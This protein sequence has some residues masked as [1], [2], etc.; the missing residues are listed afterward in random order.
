M[1]GKNAT[2]PSPVLS[3][4]DPKTGKPSQVFMQFMTAF[5]TNPLG[6]ISAASDAA[7]ATAGVEIGQLYLQN[8]APTVRR[9]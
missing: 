1:A 8:G 9:T 6:L 4:H 3:W 7:A 2:L 5:A